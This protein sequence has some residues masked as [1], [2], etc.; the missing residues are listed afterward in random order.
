MSVIFHHSPKIGRHSAFLDL[1]AW[2]GFALP[3]LTD[4]SFY[5]GF[6][7]PFLMTHGRWLSKSLVQLKLFDVGKDR[8]IGLSKS[9]NPEINY[10]PG[11]L[12]QKLNVDGLQIELEVCFVSN[13]SVLVRAALLN[14]SDQHL[15]LRVSWQ[16]NIFLEQAALKSNA[17]GV[18][19]ILDKRT[20]GTLDS[21][22]SCD[23]DSKLFLLGF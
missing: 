10:Y 19:I 1:G 5:G 8:S 6:A 11:R 4:T 18:Q 20:S 15:K 14:S 13:R 2:H 23:L 21:F 12:S 22:N 9:L 3:G 7:G 16:G 17:S